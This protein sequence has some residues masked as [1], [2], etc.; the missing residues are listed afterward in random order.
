M[1]IPM[2]NQ[3][4]NSVVRKT[5]QVTLDVNEEVRWEAVVVDPA[6][7]KDAL[8]EATDLQQMGVMRLVFIK[9]Q[10]AEAERFAGMASVCP[11]LASLVSNNPTAV[12]V[13]IN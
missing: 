3:S 10:E 6:L 4:K 1:A 12:V 8:L 11:A 7:L 9:G 5:F 13:Q 2:V